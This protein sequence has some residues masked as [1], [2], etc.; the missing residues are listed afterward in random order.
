MFFI[1][2]VLGHVHASTNLMESNASLYSITCLIRCVVQYSIATVLRPLSVTDSEVPR[3][4]LLPDALN[5]IDLLAAGKLIYLSHR[6]LCLMDTYLD[7]KA[8]V[9]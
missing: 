9:T 5:N 7:T 2:M 4:L 3:L 6:V 1:Q 8:R